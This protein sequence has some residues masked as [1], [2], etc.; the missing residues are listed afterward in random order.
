MTPLQKRIDDLLALFEGD[1][2]IP[3][4]GDR[5][6]QFDSRDRAVWV[7]AT[8][9]QL[10]RH[11]P[12]ESVGGELVK[13]LGMT[14]LPGVWTL[15]PR[16]FQP[17]TSE[18]RNR[19]LALRSLADGAMPNGVREKEGVQPL[20]LD[21]RAAAVFFENPTLTKKQI[22]QKIGCK[23]QSLAPDRC[24]KLTAAMKALKESERLKHGS[25]SKGGIVEAW[26]K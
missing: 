19:L 4:E 20:S 5:R 22:A 3:T 13:H 18:W 8:K 17:F 24:P 9:W 14:N 6:N 25:K 12:E 16:V 11:L 7:E 21:A 23:P 2:A 1:E 26:K 15:I 10:D